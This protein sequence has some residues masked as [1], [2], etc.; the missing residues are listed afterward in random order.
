MLDSLVEL[1]VCENLISKHTSLYPLLN[2]HH[3]NVVCYIIS[4]PHIFTA[5][6]YLVIN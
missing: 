6:A 4:M 2:L 1:D 3:L 5:A